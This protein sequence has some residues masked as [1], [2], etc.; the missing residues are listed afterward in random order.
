MTSILHLALVGMES[1]QGLS[2]YAFTLLLEVMLKGTLFLLIAAAMALP[3]RRASAASRH[4]VW[5]L[6]LSATLVLPILSLVLPAWNVPILSSFPSLVTGT[7]VIISR[8]SAP[9]PMNPQ[10]VAASDAWKSALPAWILFLWVVGSILLVARMAVGEV[11]VR[12]LAARSRR[13]QTISVSSILET[14]SRRLRV[15]RAVELR[16]STEIAIPFTRGILR[17]AIIL[18]E[19][20]REWPQRQLE[21]VLAHEFAHVHRH[22]YVTQVLAQLACALS[23]FHPLVWIAAAQMRKERECA[24]DDV[25]LSVG[26]QAADYAEFLLALG[27]CL[28]KRNPVYSTTVAMAQPSQLEVRMKALLDSKLNHRLLPASR[29]LFAAVLAFALLVPAAAVHALAKNETGGEKTGNISGTVLE[30]P[31][32]VNVSERQATGRGIR[33]ASV[34]LINAKTLK[35]ISTTTGEDGSFEF[36][37]LVP[38]RYRI[39][40]SKTGFTATEIPN[41][42]LKPSG[43]LTVVTTISPASEGQPSAPQRAGR[44]KTLRIR[45]RGQ[46]EA[47]KL[48]Y[49]PPPKYPPIAKIAGIQGTVKLD[50]VID[51]KGNVK[52]L[53]VVSGHPLLAKAALDAVKDWRFKPTLLNGV[54]VGVETTVTVIFRDNKETR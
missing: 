11:R 31:F 21:F 23:W 25:V 40:F 2:G 13:F 43:N 38:G 30:P 26:H 32:N 24:C 12:K 50:A 47:E 22:D 51:K 39:I 16:T 6:A 35:K 19:A 7:P 45:I 29:V 52:D 41:L 18:P 3:L 28:Q 53:K 9:G 44:S 37:S 10:I 27:R 34:V 15:F 1:L 17:P 49:S 54:P 20:S 4:L 46:V 5:T 8:N 36:P 42:H 48:I 33:G 14:A